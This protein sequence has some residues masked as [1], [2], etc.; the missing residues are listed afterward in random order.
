MINRGEINK[1]ERE[2]IAKQIEEFQKQG[3]MIQELEACV[4]TNINDMPKSDY[5]KAR[6]RARARYNAKKKKEAKRAAT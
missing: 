2:E 3:G 5:E 1:S 4:Y 6:E